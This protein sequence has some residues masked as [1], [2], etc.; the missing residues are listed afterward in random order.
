MTLLQGYSAI[1]V[2]LGFTH[3]RKVRGD[4]YCGVRAALYQVLSLGLPL[5]SG[6]TTH[7]CLASELSQGATWLHE[8][9]FGHRLNFTKE[10]ILNG[11]WECLDA[12]DNMVSF[13]VFVGKTKINLIIHN[14]YTM[15]V[16]K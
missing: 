2:E 16:C 12:L 8:W 6:H 10:Q 7:S 3:L 13:F 15:N 1:P 14:S 11:F 5:P 4:N 9:S